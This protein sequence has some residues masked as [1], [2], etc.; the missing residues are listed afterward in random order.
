MKFSLK[1]SAV[2]TNGLQIIVAC[3]FL[4]N[5]LRACKRIILETNYYDTKQIVLDIFGI[6]TAAEWRTTK[7]LPL[8]A[9][10]SLG[11]NGKSPFWK[12]S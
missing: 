3:V 6:R 5:I 4:Y 12:C 2:D 9:M 7:T 11:Y 8:Q 10:M 1:K